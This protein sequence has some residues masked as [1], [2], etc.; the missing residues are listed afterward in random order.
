[1]GI[2]ELVITLLLVG[3]VLALWADKAGIPYPALLALAGAAL[4]LIPGTPQ[5]VLDPRLALALFVS[6]VL[7][8]AAFDASPRDLKQNLVAVSSLALMAVGVTIVAVA[9]VA[10]YLVP[11]MSWPAAVALGAIVAPPDTSAATAVLRRLRPPHRLVV[12]LQGESLFNDASALLVY[13]FAV[14]AAMTGAVSGWSVAPMFV[15]TCGGGVVLGVVLARLYLWATAHI[16]D[17]P[18]SVILQFIGTFA[19]WLLADRL[20]LSAILTVI[21]YAMTIARR[22]G[23][24]DARHRISSYAV[25]DVAVFVLNVLAFVMIGLQ[26]RGIVTR[27]KTS[28]WHTYLVCAG[29]VC[30]TVVVVRILWVMVMGA[31]ARWRIRHFGGSKPSV[32]MPTFGGALIVAWCGMR[33]IVTLAT[34]LALPDGS[35]TEAFPYRDLIILCAF[36]VVLTTLVVQGMT[37]RP[38]LQWAGLKDDGSVDRE[39]QLARAQTARAALKVLEGHESRPAIETLR[40]GYEARVR[41]GQGESVD[42][43]H[44]HEGSDLGELQRRA[45]KAQREA[46]IDLRARSIIGDDAFHAAEEEIDLLE[47]A[48]DERIRPR[49]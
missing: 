25:W 24:V 16:D 36:C 26:L 44:E 33:G 32:T 34:A 20:G 7:L 9:F 12:I 3:A 41:L 38:L 19:V 17:I 45:V 37:L 13:R 29:A 49:A 43:Q 46:L 5:V 23:R 28:E 8:D 21:A 4:T 18:V 10:R 6:P 27:M 42:D 2:F 35:P 31:V 40:R 47:L 15:L 11:G 30:L 39:I 14:A 22:A 1:M 48:A